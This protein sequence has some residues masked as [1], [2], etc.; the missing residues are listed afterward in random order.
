ML[1]WTFC[2]CVF[3]VSSKTTRQ[4]QGQLFHRTAATIVCMFSPYMCSWTISPQ[5]QTVWL[6]MCVPPGFGKI[7][8]WT[9]ILGIWDIRSCYDKAAWVGFKCLFKQI[10]LSCKL[11]CAVLKQLSWPSFCS[12]PLPP[13]GSWPTFS[14]FTK[15]AHWGLLTFYSP[16]QEY[17]MIL[18][19][20]N[21]YVSVC[22]HLFLLDLPKIMVSS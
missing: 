3:Y 4:R 8:I 18:S 2:L 9:K 11:C 5:M 12:N 19:E 13:L 14:Q 6:K 21:I 10:L 7:R 1:K 16:W 15:R 17:Q 22:T 20:M